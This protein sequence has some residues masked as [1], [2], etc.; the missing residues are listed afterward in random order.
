MSIYAFSTDNYIIFFFKFR[1]TI[2]V[3]I[4]YRYTFTKRKCFIKNLEYFRT[5]VHLFQIVKQ[6]YTSIFSCTYKLKHISLCL[7]CA[8]IL[9]T[10]LFLN[11]EKVTKKVYVRHIYTR[12]QTNFCF[13][14][15][16]RD[17][18]TINTK[19]NHTFKL[20]ND[21]IHNKFLT[22]I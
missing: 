15:S 12:I 6:S 1:C 13:H 17:F 7:K 3:T 2:T 10:V 9:T 11:Q 14:L 21:S 19:S 5:K 8:M 16:K 22:Q 18:F 4:P 20:K